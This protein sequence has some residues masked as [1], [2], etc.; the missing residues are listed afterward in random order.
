MEKKTVKKTTKTTKSTNSIKPLVK[1]FNIY[2]Y[3][4]MVFSIGVIIVGLF[5]LL[6]PA[7][8]TRTAEIATA[9]CLIVIG[10]GL[11]FNN[12]FKSKLSILDFSLVFG[13]IAMILGVLIITN[14]FSLTN[15]LAVAFGVFLIINGLSKIHFAINFKAM[16]ESC[17]LLIL[18]IAI[19][20]IVFGI[21][22]I[23]DP[24]ANLYFTQMIGLFM[25]LYGVVEVTYM[26]L[27]KQRSKDFLKL[28]K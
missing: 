9:V 15:F 24:F 3:Q 10:L 7:L 14:P 17:W 19:M 20:S 21:M 12:T 8:A 18:A 13:I 23:V 2:F 5:L 11:A 1:L 22:V 28:L 16:K 26:I 25:I 4:F 6:K 27:L